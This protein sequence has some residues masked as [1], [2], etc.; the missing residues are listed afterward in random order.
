[1]D[2]LLKTVGLAA[3][4][5][6]H[7]RELDF[8]KRR[9][10]KSIDTSKKLTE[11]S[12]TESKRLYLLELFNNLL[13]HFQQ[14]NADLIAST[15]E[16]ERDMFDQR[17]QGLQTIL[18]SASVMFGALSTVIVNSS[19]P[20]GVIS[21]SSRD[22]DPIIWVFGVSS[23]VSFFCLLIC[24]VISVETVSLASLFNYHSRQL[25][26]ALE[27]TQ[28]VMHKMREK[29]LEVRQLGNKTREESEQFWRDHDE[30]LKDYIF[31]REEV[32][33]KLAFMSLERSAKDDNNIEMGS[34][35]SQRSGK[36]QNPTS[37]LDRS[38]LTKLPSVRKWFAD[39]G[40]SETTLKQ[41][42]QE[43]LRSYITQSFEEF[44]NQNCRISYERAILLFY[45]GT[46]FLLISIAVYMYAKFKYDYLDDN[47]S[48]SI[49]IIAA[50]TVIAVMM[51]LIIRWTSVLFKIRFNH[52]ISATSGQTN[53]R[54]GAAGG[55]ILEE[56]ADEI[57]ASPNERLSKKSNY[58][59]SPS[60]STKTN[61]TTSRGLRP[62]A[63]EDNC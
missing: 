46:G 45:L 39:V 32:N 19:L 17:N 53:E 35:M 12:L 58:L 20:D 36:Q 28:E 5:Y 60:T 30:Q 15:K 25:N 16:A 14:L 48:L 37:K 51:I 24:M 50:V 1:M 41:S 6:C 2:N 9:Y 29:S 42:D 27:R 11:K 57:V 43:F 54:Q 55:A 63:A 44:W 13:Q 22:K 33:N 49:V 34:G 26:A 62:N 4:F 7:K 61:Y 10:E 52:S 59:K 40:A 3:Q 21:A 47:S 23:A 31:V 56:K 38:A 8:A 18:L